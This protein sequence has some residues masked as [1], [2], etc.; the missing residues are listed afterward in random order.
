MPRTQ[1][2]RRQ[3]LNG[4]R[5]TT[6]RGLDDLVLSMPALSWNQVFLEVDRLSRAG[7]VQ[8]IS[9]DGVYWLRLGLHPKSDE[10]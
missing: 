7:E 6:E 3:I 9:R 8:I 4:L 1:M 10:R 5:K 2:I